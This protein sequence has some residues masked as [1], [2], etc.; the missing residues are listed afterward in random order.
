MLFLDIDYCAKMP[1][2]LITL[3]KAILGLIQFLIP[4]GLILMGTIDFG[5]SVFAGSE[6]EIKKNQQRFI[7]R[8]I[9]AVLVFL[10]A[11]IVRAVISFVA[12]NNS[13]LDCFK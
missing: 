13:A 6:D 2:G 3:I 11:T 5:K 9:A 10:V 4:M 12:N 7:Q 8:L 1:E